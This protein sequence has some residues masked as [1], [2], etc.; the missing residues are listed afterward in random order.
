MTQVT[1]LDAVQ[2]DGGDSSPTTGHGGAQGLNEW[3]RQRQIDVWRRRSSDVW[4]AAAAAALGKRRWV[5]RR[6]APG[7]AEGRR[8]EM[9]RWQGGGQSDGGRRTPGE[10]RG[11]GWKRSVGGLFIPARGRRRC[12]RRLVCVGRGGGHGREQMRGAAHGGERE[13]WLPAG[14]RNTAPPSS[15]PPPPHLTKVQPEAG[16]DARRRHQRTTKM[17]GTSGAARVGEEGRGRRRLGGGVRRH[18]GTR[19][20]RGRRLAEVGERKED[21]EREEETSEDEE[22]ER[23]KKGVTSLPPLPPLELPP[24]KLH[25]H[26]SST[27]VTTATMV[28]SRERR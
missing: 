26:A 4:T 1:Q 23:G 28:G 25:L 15:L 7:E 24:Q 9:E 22:E 8:V 21:R 19:G 13:E 17:T 2:R 27:S 12:R 6:W 14:E 11:G 16:R 10:Q 20:C 3:R 5:E 18:G